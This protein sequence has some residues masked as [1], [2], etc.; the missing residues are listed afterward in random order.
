M[1]LVRS[2][3]RSPRAERRARRGTVPLEPTPTGRAGARGCRRRDETRRSGTRPGGC[4]T[5]RARW[6]M[7]PW[8]GP[9]FRA[10]ARGHSRLSLRPPE[11][12]ARSVSGRRLKAPR[13]TSPPGRRPPP[14]RARERWSRERS[15]GREAPRR[16]AR[17]PAS[18]PSPPVGDGRVAAAS[19]GARQGFSCMRPSAR[20][21]FRTE[22]ETRNVR[23]KC[24]CSCVLQFTCRRAVCGVLHRPTCQVIHRSGLCLRLPALSRGAGSR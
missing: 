5:R 18:P 23:S 12:G 1:R 21:G 17:R 8:C 16:T 2:S 15:A 20:R 13:P 3:A 14:S 19:R 6:Q 11:C 24:R 22:S 9:P 4:G 7:A 10:G